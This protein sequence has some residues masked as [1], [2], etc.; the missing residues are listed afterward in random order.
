MRRAKAAGGDRACTFDAA[1]DPAT[2]ARRE[3]RRDLDRAIAEDVLD[4]RFQPKVT[5]A[6]GRMA[7]AEALVRWFTPAGE[8]VPPDDFIPIAEE[9]GLI[10]PLGRAVLARA[11]HAAADWPNAGAVAVNL[12]PVQLE[13]DDVV[14]MVEHALAH[15]GL[16]PH[17]LELE[18]TEQVLLE[19]VDRVAS[20][21]GRL[22][23]LGVALAL[24]DFG[25]GY[26]SFAMLRR[27]PL[28]TLKLDRSFARALDLDPRAADVVAGMVAMAHRLGLATVAEGVET[29]GQRDLLRR[30]GCD[31]GQGFFF[32]RPAAVPMLEADLRARRAHDRGRGRASRSRARSAALV[33]PGSA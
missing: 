21:L 3:R 9:S 8:E 11:C 22:R 15:S 29:A 6:T 20:T 25:S 14:A 31:L 10:V 1:V 13:R 16:P 32:G 19:D 7:G 2:R 30:L 24:D 12:S 27:L 5:L 33:P 17:R 18:V 26:L 4:V 23:D 28:D